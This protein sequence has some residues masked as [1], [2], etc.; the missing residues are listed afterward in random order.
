MRTGSL[1]EAG[2]PHRVRDLLLDCRLMEMIARGRTPPR[3]AADPHGGKHEL[4]PPVSRGVR[5]LAIK[6]ER[7]NNA[8]QAFGQIA[9]VL[10][11]HLSQL[12]PEPGAN[13]SA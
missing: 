2:A 10:P 6:R 9:I 8:S 13:G 12:D 7:E 11:L 3:I 4:P 1:R 5:I